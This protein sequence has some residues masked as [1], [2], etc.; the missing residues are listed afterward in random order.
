MAK[1][2]SDISYQETAL[3]ASLQVGAKAIQSSLFDYL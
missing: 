1:T 2:I 3:E